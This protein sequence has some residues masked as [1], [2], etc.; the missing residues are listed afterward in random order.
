MLDLITL[1]KELGPGPMRFAP[2]EER[3]FQAQM[4]SLSPTEKQCFHNLKEKWNKHIEEN[5]EKEKTPTHSYSDEMILRF[6]RCSPGRNKFEET[7]SWK[8]MK[9]FDPRFLTLTAEEIEKQ[10]LSKTLFPVPG[11][12]TNEGHDIFY[13]YPARYFPKETTTEEIIDNLGYCMNTMCEME[14]A[15]SEGI[16][17]M[18]Y[19]NDWK[20]SNFSIDYC[21]QFMMMLQGRVPV[22]VRM[23]LIVNPPSWFGMIWKI[24]KPMLSPDFRKKVHVIK[25]SKIGDF[26]MEGY[27]TYLPDET[28]T[29]KADTESMVEDFV[30]Y[31]KA[32]EKQTM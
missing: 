7:A 27:E 25:E 13:M 5:K 21:Y 8:V 20:M 24:M 22:R 32:A 3:S 26:L 15:S 31:R 11:L 16:G 6:A 19:M 2:K 9:K 14:K 30:T 12:K 1:E 4:E 28:A 18:A 23:F 17:F 10:L 29:G